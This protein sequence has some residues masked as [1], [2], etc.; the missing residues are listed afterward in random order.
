MKAGC[1]GCIVRIYAIDL[2][3]KSLFSFS[4]A[5]VTAAG[6]VIIAIVVVVAAVF[7]APLIYSICHSKLPFRA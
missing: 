6:G 5:T 1:R 2:C 4:I 3:L 7:C